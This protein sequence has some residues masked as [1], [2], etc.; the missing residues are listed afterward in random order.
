MM[1]GLNHVPFSD[2]DSERL[3]RFYTEGQ[4]VDSLQSRLQVLRWWP[5]SAQ[6]LYEVS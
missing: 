1:H 5:K 3:S 6:V 2:S 4:V